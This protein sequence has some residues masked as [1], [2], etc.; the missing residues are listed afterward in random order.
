VGADPAALP[1]AQL[2]AW[3]EAGSAIGSPAVAASAEPAEASAPF[4]PG[5]DRSPEAAP[6]LGSP[7]ATAAAVPEAA[8][9]G[10]STAASAPSNPIPSRAAAPVLAAAVDP[11][12]RFAASEA[13]VDRSPLPA[14]PAAGSSD[15]KRIRRSEGLK[16]RNPHVIA[17]LAGGGY[18]FSSADSSRVPLVVTVLR[19]TLP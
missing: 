15:R 14:P 19:P 3:S 6:V 2:G 10:E 1:E 18:Q 13:A 5:P 9:A 8:A 4:D 11:V 17:I 7:S 12:G 16:P